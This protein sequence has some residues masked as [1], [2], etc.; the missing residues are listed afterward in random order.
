MEKKDGTRGFCIDYYELNSIM[1]KDKFL[2]PIIDDL[3]DELCSV[4]I[5]SKIDLRSGY[6]HIKDKEYDIPKTAFCTHH[7]YYKFEVM[8]FGLTNALATF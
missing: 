3:L 7:G 1:V 8:L 2:I 5:F 4:S 6:H